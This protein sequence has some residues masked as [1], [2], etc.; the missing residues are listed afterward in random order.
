MS[1]KR[2]FV[3]NV[4]ASTLTIIIVDAFIRKGSWIMFYLIV[5]KFLQIK[6]RECKLM[7]NFFFF[8]FFFSLEKFILLM[9]LLE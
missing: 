6:F 4:F 8:F 1:R 7:I 3:L 9:I 5:E 2:H